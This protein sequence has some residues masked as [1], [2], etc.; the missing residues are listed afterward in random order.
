M[1][2]RTAQTPRTVDDFR[3]WLR[4]Q[5]KTVSQWAREHEFPLAAVY[6]V[7][8]GQNKAYYGQAHAIAVAAGLKVPPQEDAGNL[9]KPIAA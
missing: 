4:S 6:R 2:K 9:Q 8:G 5:G 1:A 7:L 3:N